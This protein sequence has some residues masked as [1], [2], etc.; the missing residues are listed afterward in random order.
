MLL[1]ILLFLSVYI[2]V[3]YVHIQLYKRNVS[4][5]WIRVLMISALLLYIGMFHKPSDV[6]SDAECCTILA[7]ITA[8]LLTGDYHTSSASQVKPVKQS[9][10]SESS[11]TEIE[12]RS[13]F[14]SWLSS[15]LILAWIFS[16][17]DE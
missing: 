3:S 13:G 16:D 8:H 4:I 2:I 12:G 11:Y 7:C 15:F 1:I 5:F 9:A 14:I 6:W 17:D 10:H